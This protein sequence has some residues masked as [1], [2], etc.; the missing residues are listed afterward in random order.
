VRPA[1]SAQPAARLVDV[2]SHP[3]GWWR[4]TAQRLLVER[5]A[6]VAS[7]AAV[8]A[9]LV[10]RAEGAPD[11]RTRVHA[12][13]TL[14]GIDRIL[15]AAV[16]RALSDES[17]EVR[18]SA[19]RIA[20]R[21]LGEAN[22]P[23]QQAVTDRI[24]DADWNVRAQV[25]ASLGSLPPGARETS[26]V[27]IL[28]RHGNDPIVLDAALSGLRGGETTALEHLLSAG[29]MQTP[30]REATL[31]MIAATIVRSEQNGPIQRVFAWAADEARPSWQRS[32]LVRGAEVAVLGAVM[33]G[34]PPPRRSLAAVLAPCPTCPGGR[35]GPGGAYAFP[36][37]QAATATGGRGGTRSVRLTGEPTGLRAIETAGAELAVRAT[38][39]LARMEWPGKPGGAAVPSL[40]PEEQGRFDAGQEVYK[41]LCAGCHQPDG[42]GQERVAPSLV[43]SS[44]ALAPAAIPV[45]ILL[46][47]K[48]GPVGLM[49]P[50][51]STLTDDQI[52]AVLTYIRREWGQA[53]TP[54]TAATVAETRAV[55]SGRTRPW[56]NEELLAIGTG[57]AR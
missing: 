43:G 12:L 6:G 55:T 22:H 8:V 3:N 24:D 48:E 17:R 32:A 16:I 54:V 49:P 52:A 45:R 57:V 29:A 9:N 15:P 36:Q 1:L 44:L 11:W 18:L 27:S 47:G 38:A 50:A 39:V 13:W 31:T 10:K 40:T 20:E 2:L 21:W 56:T 42:R 4:D 23:I 5:G 7:D 34:T 26:I 53:G 35:G 51:G 14:D 19:V 41:N 33:P 25:A 28:E 37:A 30:A 46:H